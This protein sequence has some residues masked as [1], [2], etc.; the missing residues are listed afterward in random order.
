MNAVVAR[1]HEAMHRVENTDCTSFLRTVGDETVDLS[2]SSCPNTLVAD[3]TQPLPF[4]SN[5]VVVF[6]SPVLEYVTDEQAAIAEIERVSG[7][8]AY[9]AGVEPFTLTA[10]FYPG[11]RRTLPARYR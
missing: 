11:A 9:F 8:H 3:V 5:S 10:H 1:S 4:A 7:G 2:G 6:C